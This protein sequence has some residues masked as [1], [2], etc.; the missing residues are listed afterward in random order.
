M[1]ALAGYPLGIHCRLLDPTPDACASGVAPVI[2]AAFDEREALGELAAGVD[3]ITYELEGVPV[4]SAA[5]LAECVPLRPSLRALQVGQDRLEEK[6]LFQR[7]GIPTAPW[8]QVD[9]AG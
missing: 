4:E 8:R 3:A 2:T 9:S 6:L 5:W 7:L 1:L